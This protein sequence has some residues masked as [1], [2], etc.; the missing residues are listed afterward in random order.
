MSRKSSKARG[1]QGNTHHSAR[2]K[3][4]KT[5]PEYTGRVQMTREGF[6]FVI[7][8]G[9]EDDIFVK[10]S[11]TRQALN[12]DTVI[13]AVTREGGRDRRREG[14][15]VKIVERSKRPFVGVYHTVGAQAWVLMQSKSMPYDIEVDAEQGAALGAH[16][17]GRAAR[18]EG[19]RRRGQ[20]EPQ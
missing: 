16:G 9:L 1:A 8:E 20:L 17:P 19:C 15:I 2:H 3:A 14:E 13:V 7:V 11:K 12:G 18:N 4:S 6:V 10:A 5:Y